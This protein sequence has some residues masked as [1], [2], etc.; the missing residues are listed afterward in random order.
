ALGGHSLLA[1]RVVSRVRDAFGVELPLRAVFEAPTVAGFAERVERVLR[2]GDGTGAPPLLPVP[3]DRP[4]P[5]SFAQR[6]LW[7]IE[8]LDPGNAAYVIPFALRLRGALDARALERSLGELVRRHE[9]LRTTFAEVDGEPVQVVGTPVPP[10]LPTVELRGMP[11][12]ERERLLLRLAGEDASRPFDLARGPLLR[13]TLVRLGEAE[14]ALLLA[15]HHIVSD[16]GSVEVLVREA[17]ELYA[18]F[19][20]GREP[21]L[22]PL[23]VQYADYA[24]WQRAWLTGETLERQ[25]AWWR[26]RL[27]GAPPTLELP[28]DRP[29]PAAATARG[30]SRRISLSPGTSAALEA[31][32]RG[33]GA[34]PFMALLAGWQA[35]LGRWSGQEDV[36]VGTPVSGRGRSE[37][38]GVVG[39]F[40]NTLVLRADLSGDPPFHTLLGRVRETTLGAYAHQELPFERLVEALHPERTAGHTPLFQTVFSLDAGE[41]GELRLGTLET[42]PLERDEEATRFDL[43]VVMRREGERLGGSLLFRSDLFDGATAERLLGHFARLLEAVAGDPERRLSQVELLAPEERRQILEEWN[44]TEGAFPRERCVHELFARQARQTPDATAVVFEE[45]RLTYAELDR[46]ADRLAH[47]LRA[48]GVGPEARVGLLLERGAE[49]VVSVLGILKAGGAYLALDPSTPD[50]RLRFVLE[51]ACACAVVTCAALADRLGG[52]RGAR[53]RLDTDRE[54]IERAPAGVPPGEVSAQS[55]AYVIYTSGS[56]G[57]PKGVLVEHRGLC[58]YLHWFDREV[59]GQC[60]FA[61]PLVSRLSFDAHVRQLFPPLLRGEAVWVLPEET[62]ADPG[63]LLEALTTRERVSFGGVP[64]LWSALLERVR[65]GEGPKPEGLVAVLLGGEAL[66]PE[67]LERTLAAFPG[68]AV[69]NH[70]GPT[71]AT[72]N[73]TAVRVEDPARVTLG[74]PIANLRVYL[75]DGRGSP[76]PVGV[77]G[78]LYVG[79]AGVSRG[80]LGRPALTAERFVPD[81]F[82]GEPGARLYRSGDRA[83]WLPTGELEYLGRIDHQVKVRGFR[84]EPGEVEMALERHPGV[85][86]AAVVAQEG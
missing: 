72:V 73:T 30:G 75:L 60:G 39:C 33:A 18:A 44:A 1:V 79:G 15:L 67:L 86:E 14:W 56:T 68:V 16:G 38:E 43:S 6:R 83:R 11:E 45:Q 7:F 42:E 47:H 76:V 71:E 35:L 26:E 58:N 80:Y 74:R 55:L 21:R 36:C 8:Q 82:A 65:V 34:T 53:V 78:E 17:S 23:P 13:A 66:G 37:T 12:G 52:F 54:A 28:T 3:R 10:P 5:L 63:A 41:G 84:I 4:L 81:P 48:L 40:V 69:W 27:A 57:T 9:A 25:L 50:E 62:V 19:T 22:P 29:R 2:A 24:A 64:S 77:P 20:E 51:D 70:Y 32:A 31:L 46:R 85:R 59:L 49:T 61:L